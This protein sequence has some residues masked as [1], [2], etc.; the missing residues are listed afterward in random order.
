MIAVAQSK[1][2]KGSYMIARA[3]RESVDA[4]LKGSTGE[5][6]A[7]LV[8]SLFQRQSCTMIKRGANHLVSLSSVLLLGVP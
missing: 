7:T 6:S 4:S 5:K 2:S 8:S 1:M 3:D